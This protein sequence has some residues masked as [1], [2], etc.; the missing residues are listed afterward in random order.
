MLKPGVLVVTLPL[1]VIDEIQPT[2][3]SATR[4]ATP[5]K[6]VFPESP[7]AGAWVIQRPDSNA[8]HATVTAGSKMTVASGTG[9]LSGPPDICWLMKLKVTGWVIVP[10][11]WRTLLNQMYE[12][13]RIFVPLKLDLI[14]VWQASS[15]R[16]A[17]G[18][19]PDASPTRTASSG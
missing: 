5:A 19:S 3:S 1:H 2:I 17:A 15:A 12:S 11:G 10:F 7:E 8:V 4:Q 6:K 14:C 9:R 13:L 18:A 16:A